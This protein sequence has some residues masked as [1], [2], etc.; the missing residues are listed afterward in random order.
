[1][2]VARLDAADG[3]LPN[4]WVSEYTGSGVVSSGPAAAVLANGKV[5]V[6]VST[7][8]GRV[9]RYKHRGRLERSGPLR[10]GLRAAAAIEA[11]ST[12]IAVRARSGSTRLTMV[13]WAA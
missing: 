2:R 10:A 13:A 8:V 4:N 9:A 7:S 3:T 12:T 11:P 5:D 1:L 6:Y